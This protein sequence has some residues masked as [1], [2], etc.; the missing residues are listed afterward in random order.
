MYLGKSVDIK[1]LSFF[2]FFF[3]AV[4]GQAGNTHIYQLGDDS[5]GTS[6]SVQDQS[7]TINYKIK[8]LGIE[9]ISGL[10]GKYFRLSA[11]GHNFTVEPGKPELPVLSRLIEIPE[12]GIYK[13]RISNVKSERIEPWRD[14]IEGFLYPA[15]YGETKQKDRGKSDFIIDKKIYGAHGIINS[16]T[17]KVEYLGKLRSVSLSTLS[18][19]PVRYNPEMNYLEVITSMKIEIIFNGTNFRTSKSSGSES[20]LFNDIMEKGVLNYYPDQVITGYTDNPVGMILVADTTFKECLKPFIKWKT[21]KGFR[22]KVIYPG[23]DGTGT[24]YQDIKQSIM[25]SYRSLEVSGSPPEYLLLIG[26]TDKIP[27]YGTGNISDMYYGEMD[28][29]GDFIPDMFVGRIPAK[30]TTEFKPVVEKI[31]KY[32]KFGFSAENT[33]Y[34]RALVIAGKDANYAG[35]MNGQVKYAITNYLNSTNKITGYHFYYP[36]GYTKKDSTLKLIDN[37]LSFIN[38]TGHGAVAGWLHLD[39]KSPDIAGMHNADMYP[40]V[41]SNACR[42]AEF[43]DTA[44]LGNKFVLAD[45]KGAIG[46]I[47]CSNDS[48]WDEDFFWA[49]GSGTPGPDPKY[50]E[51]GLGAYDRLFHTHGEIASDWYTTIGQVN[52]AGNL[53]VSSTTSLRKKY[54][55]E[56]YSVVGDPS[57]SPILGKPGNLSISVPDTLP[58]GIRSLTIAGDPYSYIAVSHFDTLWDASYLSPSGTAVLEFPV[59]SYDSCLVVVTGQNRVPV[60]KT[61]YFSDINREYLSLTKT[62]IAD[63]LG[64]NN[65]RADFGETI[66][67]NLVIS[68]LGNKD[69]TN[70]SARIASS[71]P[72]ITINKSSSLIGTLYAK[73]EVKLNGKLELKIKDNIPDRG[74]VT[75]DLFLKDDKGEKKLRI[76]IIIHSPELEIVN[77]VIDDSDSGNNNFIADPGETFSLVFQ[78]RNLGTSST[79]GQIEIQ[80]N[81]NDLTILEPNVKSGTLQFGENSFIRVNAKL[82]EHAG[83][84]D[85]ISLNSTLNCIPYSANRDFTFR[86]G[87]VRESFESA[88]F[89]VF[90]WVNLSQVPWIINRTNSADGIASARSGSISHNES[91]TLLIRTFYPEADTLK[92]YYKVSSEQNYDNLKFSLNGQELLKASGETSWIKK[93]I[94]IPAGFNK[95]EWSYIKDNSVS[96]GEDCAWVDLID[97][98]VSHP[99]QY[100]KRDLEVARIVNPVQKNSYEQEPV[101]VRLYNPGRDTINGFNLAYTVNDNIPVRQNF[102]TVIYPYR[103]SVTVTFDRRANLDL[104][105]TYD[106]SVFGYSNDDDC[107]ANDTLRISI[108]N[109][110]L[111]ENVKAYPN[112]FTEKINVLITVN[113]PARMRICLTDGTGRVISEIEKDIIS[114]PNLVEISTPGISCSMYFLSVSATGF[115]KVIPLIKVRK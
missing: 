42:T 55:W 97:F 14:K 95:I 66:Y 62:I 107:P 53:S 67:L 56:T 40:F 28:G 27:Y 16:D 106:I 113:N 30:D 43:S 102:T 12:G 25:L 57:I 15:Q 18:V 87:K 71:S 85:F 83:F 76:D 103:D 60:I 74:L 88:N 98:S 29:D 19:C 69:A 73:S 92:F 45:R 1:S 75:V 79:S 11:A 54:Y 70:L 99:L 101:T 81:D 36:D 37:G 41:I 115:Y 2:L 105:G 31:L 77:C 59:S 34:S 17:V 93:A 49:V 8:S 47:G 48:Y 50:T 111:N 23:K 65:G 86:V 32:E 64:N 39:L 58:K 104:N 13:I 94:S 84:G 51:T 24:R 114:G 90:P 80:S 89:R 82:S 5:E 7:I 6:I 78:V 4:S 26:N 20:A 61:V 46:F 21:Q 108:L 38:Y 3:P 110:E 112:P 22:I 44:S 100:I 35:Y 72:W 33:F 96:Q 63:S 9:T 109:P 91:T 68:N 10:N 52:Y